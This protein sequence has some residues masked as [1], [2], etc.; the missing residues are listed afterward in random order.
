MI[1]TAAQGKD[2]RIND[3]MTQRMRSRAAASLDANVMK[4]KSGG[5]MAAVISNA[6]KLSLMYARDAP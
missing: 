4:S 5:A 6:N 3:K 2:E 1:A